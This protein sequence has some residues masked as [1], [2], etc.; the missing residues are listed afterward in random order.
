MI[1]NYLTIA[2]RSLQKKLGFTLVN[3]IGLSVGLTVCLLIVIFVQ[4]EFSYDK[5]QKDDIYRIALNRIY[6][7]RNVKYAIIPHSIAPQMVIDFPEVLA[8]TCIVTA[9]APVVFRAKDNYFFEE[10][11]LFADTNVFKVLNIPLVQGDPETALRENN[12]V[13]ISE[14]T[15]KKYF[16]ESSAMGQT[17]ETDFG[18][19]I[20]TGIAKD[21]PSNSHFEFDFLGS[22][23]SFGNFIDQPNFVGF[24]V[25]SYIKLAPGANPNQLEEKIPNFIKQY[26]AGAIQQR[27][28]IS[29]DEYV[30][31]GNGYIYTLQA[32]EDIH[33]NSNLEGE[34]KPNGNIT[35][36]YIFISAAFFI[37]LIATINFMNLATARSTERA[38]EVGIR[39]VLGSVRQQLIYQFIVES[40]LI[41]LISGVVAAVLLYFTLPLFADISN[42]ELSLMTLITPVNTSLIVLG[43]LLIGFLAGIY[44]AFVL[45][46]FKPVEVLKGKM[47][48]SKHGVFLRN[49][50]VVFQFT[51]SITLIACTI[52]I[53]DQ[54]NF[55]VNRS[56]GFDEEDVV[57][58]ENVFTIN[59]D[60]FNAENPD[61]QQIRSR[62]NTLHN[63]MKSVAGVRAAAYTS[64]MPG[65][66]LPGYIIR[67]SGSGE[68]ESLVARSVVVDDNFLTTMNLKLLE[69]RFFSKDFN[70]TL[71]MV[72][73]AA[74][75][76]KLG[77]V[78]P[79]GKQI[80]N[81]NDGA[82]DDINY[83]IVGVVDDFHLQSLHVEAEPLAL[84]SLDGAVGG[85]NKLVLKVDPSQLSATLSGLENNWN[86]FSKKTPFRYYFLDED[87]LHFYDS[88]STSGK[89]FGVFTLLAILIA[90]SGLLG[91]AAYAASQRKK[92]IGVRKVMGAS[93][94]NIVVLL[95]SDFTKLILIATFIAIPLAWYGMSRWLE[96]FAYRVDISVWSFVFAALSALLIGWLT[97]SYQSFTA[98]RANPVTTLRSE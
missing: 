42:S 80:I 67:V 2:L 20:V 32:I 90:C 94:L 5:F 84:L 34:I 23:R 97:V 12:T 78:D 24:D 8:S 62:L 21:Y 33:L 79:I 29:Y 81:V 52:I 46:S 37:M 15:A 86:K 48:N 41:T 28:G 60:N 63:E 98:A 55:L 61:I 13:V 18:N 38:K 95:S 68:K 82:D 74:T 66:Q 70:D 49:G 1:R 91:L 73:T 31:A 64:A 6:P 59:A 58:I 19:F 35:Y 39:K 3:V 11:V 36:V 83:T 4:Y 65:D 89:M 88:E 43:L 72:L 45:S 96:N 56:M 76:K 26:A 53:F 77:L 10:K 7:E 25:L 30:A 44:P 85:A 17:F 75:V 40:V 71:S 54:M 92:E 51:I 93:V 50:L 22:V 9:G 14:R 27:N 87:L 16:G 57:V 47:Q 69:G